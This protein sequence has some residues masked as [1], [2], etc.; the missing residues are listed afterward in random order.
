[1]PTLTA[2]GEAVGALLKARGETVAVAESSTGGLIAAALLA[3][4][5]A[6]AYFVGGG[7]IYTHKAREVLLEE[8]L[9]RHPGMRPATEA[10]ALLEASAIR[11]R[12]G[13]TWGIGETGA[14]GPTGNRYGDSPGHSCIA[15]AGPQTRSLTIET[16]QSDREANMWRFAEAALALLEEV[17]R[18][19][20]GRDRS[21]TAVLKALAWMAL[22]TCGPGR[23]QLGCAAKTAPRRA[24]VGR[25]AGARLRAGAGLK[26][27]SGRPKVGRVGTFCGASSRRATRRR[28]RR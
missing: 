13:T 24:R 2:M 6:S 14:T 9:A 18:D 1:M 26:P 8:D 5:G 12:L 23:M 7:V 16:G 21:E 11:Q 15:V 4:P 22:A 10:Y 25:P 20:Q 3:A 28:A 27:R 19:R 17:L